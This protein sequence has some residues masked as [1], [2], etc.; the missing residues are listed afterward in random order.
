MN[1]TWT[2]TEIAGRPADVYDPANPPRLAVLHLHDADG[3]TLRDRPAF[4]RLF[5]EL[6]LGCVCPQ[7]GPSWW[8]DRACPGF[9]LPLTPERYLLDRVLPYFGERWGVGPPGI[10]LL[11]AGMGGQGALR[12]AF[13]H[14]KTFAVAAA[15][16]PAIDYYELYGRGT[17]LDEIYDSKEQCRQ[18]TVPLH[19]HPSHAPPHLFFAVDP[20]DPWSRGSDRLHEKLS[21]LGIAHEFDGGTRAGGHSWGYFERMAERALRFV[22]AGLVQQGRRLL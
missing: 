15:V 16:A 21:A 11:G 22:H 6:G 2:T 17:P 14:P 4:T 3:Q 18:D 20:D 9:D 13:R 5:D 10:G 19:V 7:G 12:L 8:V 1:G